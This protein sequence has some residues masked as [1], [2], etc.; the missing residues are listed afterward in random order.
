MAHNESEM[1]PP[2]LT[3]A[4]RAAIFDKVAKTVERKFFD[5]NFNGTAW[6]KRAAQARGRI[7]KLV[8]PEAFESAIDVVRRG[9]R[10]SVV[11]MF[12]S[13]SVSI[14]LGIWWARSSRACSTRASVPAP[15][16]ASSP[17]SKRSPPRARHCRRRSA[18]GPCG[19][20]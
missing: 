19:Q 17:T 18:D 15:S 8:D 14:P 12:T 10:V 1:R 16:S 11:G 5:P 4:Q 9:G 3:D 13:E 20:V 7:V 2:Q 6:P